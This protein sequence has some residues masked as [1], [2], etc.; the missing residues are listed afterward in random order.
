MS[1]IAG[2]V[3]LDGAPVAPGQLQAMLAPMRRRGPDHQ[4][5]LCQDKAGFGQALL[6]TTP[7][8]LAERQPWVHPNSGCMVVSDSR[9]DHRPQLLRELGIARPAD[10]VGDGELLHAAWQRWGEDCVER[11]RGDF[12]F[13]LW[14][15]RRQ[16][17][18]CARD[19]MGVRPFLFHHHPGRLFVFGSST[20]AVLA[21]GEVP[22]DMDEGRIADALI[23]ETEGIDQTCTF[24]RAVQRL[25]PAHWMRLHEGKL[26]QRR[27]WRPIG[28]NRPPGL[29]NTEPEWIEAQRERL[30]RAVRL[31]LRS[32][33]PVGSMLSGGLDSSSV[34]A[35]AGAACT[36]KGHP[37]FPIFSATNS[38]DPGCLETRAICAVV[39]QV[40]CAPTFVDLPDF[41]RSRSRTHALWQEAGEP[42][43]GSMPLVAALYEAAA[44]QGVASLLDGVPA[45]NLYATGR[46]A[47]CLFD[48]G[49]WRETWQ[50]ALTQWQ[51]PWIRF[52]RLN[53]LRVMAGCL[54]PASVH[55]LRDRLA[56]AREYRGLL[57]ANLVSREFA[58]RV[59]LRQ[60]YRRY[61][62]TI[63]G[64]H[65]WHESGQALSSLAAP[66]ITA[67][68]ERYNRVASLFGVEPRPPFA[69]RDLIEF[70]AWMPLPL[71][72]RDGHVKWV[73]RQ[74]MAGLLPPEVTW[75][76]DKSHV[77]WRFNRALLEQALVAGKPPVE[78]GDTRWLDPDR[79]YRAWRQ[80]DTEAGAGLQ[81]ALRTLQWHQRGGQD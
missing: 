59:G 11:L 15:P 68:L 26:M 2:L 30:D 45:D 31:R 24:Y 21:Q 23:G 10:E 3:R 81:N 41:E 14:D 16:T 20:E 42:F 7:E 58:Q 69:D 1:G 61:R 36:T 34:V 27:Y 70:Q 44:A 17:L 33:R 13:A 75:R 37:P 22:R 29:P 8:A 56:E 67:G 57:R 6:A 51:L 55:A 25:P 35:L 73:L 78:T 62:Q 72:I 9:L 60:R 54:A 19:P 71:R 76:R 52:P 47:Q 38:V 50:A 80:P 48:Q 63:G 46:Q 65:Q 4:A 64:S 79:L 66:Y 39:A 74:A 43:D 18:F 53:A 40:H 32:Q 49:R 5:W 77:G 12:A 28:E